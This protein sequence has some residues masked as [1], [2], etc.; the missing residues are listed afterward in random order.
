MTSFES[1]SFSAEPKDEQPKIKPKNLEAVEKQV[2]SIDE[3]LA[4]QS[5]ML[6][7][8]LVFRWGEIGETDISHQFVSE[9]IDR[10]ASKGVYQLKILAGWKMQGNAFA[11]PDG[12]IVLTPQIIEEAE[13]VEEIAGILAHEMVHIEKGHS[14]KMM[15]RQGSEDLNTLLKEIGF[16]RGTEYEADLRAAIETLENAEINP[17]G[18]KEFL[19]RMS[20][21]ES[22]PGIV[23][24]HSV[25]RALNLASATHFIDLKALETDFHP[26]PAEI[27]EALRKARGQSNFDKLFF[28]PFSGLE[29]K[30]K[31]AEEE[32]KGWEE[33][34]KLLDKI[35]P[36]HAIFAVEAI[37]QSIRRQIDT[38][39]LQI[40]NKAV[41]KYLESFLPTDAKLSKKDRE[42]LGL[43]TLDL[44]TE[45]QVVAPVKIQ[46]KAEAG[47]D[48]AERIE[49]KQ[50]ERFGELVKSQKDLLRLR[51]LVVD[52]FEKITV[53]PGLLNTEVSM[54]DLV[55]RTITSNI[56]GNL[57]DENFEA[58]NFI[59]FLKE[60]SE[61]FE[62]LTERFGIKSV[63]K[64]QIFGK[65]IKLVLSFKIS[66]KTSEYIA[67][68]SPEK[69]EGVK[70]TEEISEEERR[71]NEAGANIGNAKSQ[72]GAEK[73]IKAL[74]K[75]SEDIF[76]DKDVWQSIRLVRKLYDSI[77]RTVTV[78]KLSKDKLLKDEIIGIYDEDEDDEDSVWADKEFIDYRQAESL[79]PEILAYKFF[80]NVFSQSESY[81]K[82]SDRERNFVR[83]FASSFFRLQDID[84]L[85]FGYGVDPNYEDDEDID[86]VEKKRNL[87]Y[88][89]TIEKAGQTD[90]ILDPDRPKS[91]ADLLMTYLYLV[92]PKER[93]GF[94]REEKTGHEA[95][96]AM[97]FNQF[98]KGKE[99]KDVIFLLDE[100]NKEGVDV[101]RVITSETRENINLLEIVS[102]AIEDESF[103]TLPLEKQFEISF[104]I[105]NVKLQQIF[106]AKIL[107]RAYPN[108]T[109]DERIALV[110]SNKR[111]HQTTYSV[112]DRFIENEVET[113]E[114]VKKCKDMLK[115]SF[116]QFF[117]GETRLL[118]SAAIFFM[119][120][121][122]SIDSNEFIEALLTSQSSE[123]VLDQFIYDS[124]T[125][126]LDPTEREEVEEA[127]NNQY[128]LDSI[129]RSLYLLEDSERQLLL[130]KLLA[131]K[132]GVL[133][134][135]DN[136]RRFLNFLFN[137]WL[138]KTGE[139][140]D[141]LKVISQVKEGLEKATDWQLLYF[142]FQGLLRDKIAIP[143]PEVSD[144]ESAE[145]IKSLIEEGK[146]D[147]DEERDEDRREIK[148]VRKGLSPIAK[149]EKRLS[150]AIGFEREKSSGNSR[151]R[152]IQFV[153][154]FGSRLGAPGV[155][156]LQLLPQIVEL[157]EEYE[158]EF[159]EIY[160]QVKGQS[161]MTA[162]TTVEREWPD[163]WT[164][165]KRFG[166]RIGGGSIMT[167]YEV[168]TATGEGQV[169]KV[170][171]P[172]VRHHLQEVTNFARLVLEELAKKYGRGYKAALDSLEDIKQW[173]EDD[174][175]F[176]DFLEKDKVFRKKNSGF[177]ADGHRYKITVPES[178]GP[179]NP[180]FTREIRISGTNLTQWEKLEEQGH[181]LKQITSILIKN[182]ASQILDG[183][184]H[185]DVHV[186]NFGITAENEVV[187][188]DRNYYLE[189]SEQERDLILSI[190]SGIG[191]IREQLLSYLNLEKT[192]DQQKIGPIIDSLAENIAK[193]NTKGAQ[194]AIAKMK[195][196]GIKIPIKITLILKNINAL[197][198][199]TKKAGFSSLFEAF[200]YQP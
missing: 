168:E 186:G 109:F 86:Q 47:S 146:I 183:Q 79:L 138:Q 137:E 119:A 169:I 103:F 174:T 104:W 113:E 194:V 184:V 117:S 150:L 128:K 70:K 143:P 181:D 69:I 111:S 123:D 23:H 5:R 158:R 167:V 161:K 92:D 125:F 114:Q 96:F 133:R 66:K 189:L 85:E 90:F 192:G 87:R 155:R 118:G 124:L 182:Y 191:N 148:V 129:K 195:Q 102:Q 35:E 135:D 62:K 131:D 77:N 144:G 1:L 21:K 46:G 63:S 140:E 4:R 126:R 59:N 196:E 10:L 22:Q 165:I 199:M 55:K 98:V 187:V 110:F 32:G 29:N 132:N 127:E 42:M 48:E 57:S 67:K 172:N 136:R 73:S 34:K 97:Y 18:L 19:D 49:K 180:Y 190:F 151:L 83:L 95:L 50:G 99:L 43:F 13:S 89:E 76:K 91:K 130:R 84:K 54:T 105:D 112:K 160:D 8:Q 3:E 101:E 15:E 16:V 120:G 38:R 179:E 122:R 37:Q 200:S 72:Y 170:R 100:L 139:E 173:I 26:I 177:T 52:N 36:H 30:K 24:G 149:V 64:E 178:V 81:K 6:V 134:T 61:V 171:N 157:P 41:N 164:E 152:P 9:I 106:R 163:V 93:G 198:E 162:I 33:R 2:E 193:Q 40:F 65:M 14:K 44:F 197:K 7:E 154:E 17:M 153:K 108:M 75:D 27:K 116:D 56:F 71:M 156:F 142:A 188:Y 51:K 31:K 121:T 115:R 107:E 145:K 58:E 60:W 53:I 11:F 82:M 88:L 175:S 166:N 20:K 78:R 176:T 80:E 141:V 39:D 185:S 147:L 74:S 159:S 94:I 45:M 25:D 28:R 68:F 12:T